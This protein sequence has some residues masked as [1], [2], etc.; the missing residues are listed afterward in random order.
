[1]IDF[2]SSPG[3]LKTMD[4][5]LK[6]RVVF[7]SDDDSDYVLEDSEDSD[8]SEESDEWN[9]DEDEDDY[10]KVTKRSR[11]NGYR[12]SFNRSNESKGEKA[13]DKCENKLKDEGIS[14]TG[15]VDYR[16]TVCVVDG[17]KKIPLQVASVNTK[18]DSSAV[19]S[20]VGSAVSPAVG[21]AVSSAAS[22][23]VS[24]LADRKPGD[25]YSFVNDTGLKI[26]Y[27][28]EY[29]PSE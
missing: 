8:E 10:R 24:L 5:S 15:P 12:S 6:S 3:K 16:P 19:G 11:T 22:S 2:S 1:M 18:Q 21:P 28:V 14:E 29:K 26:V 17:G 9:S 13:E 20:A 25:E 23:G 27:G 7:S 4:K